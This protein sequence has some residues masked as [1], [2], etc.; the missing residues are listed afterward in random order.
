MEKHGAEKWSFI[1]SF[2]PERVGKQCRERWFNHLNP[3]VKKSTW[4]KEEEWILFLKHNEF[5]NK[6]SKLCQYLPGRTDNTIKN[7]W[8]S[9]MQKKILIFET[10]LSNMLQGKSPEEVESFKENFINQCKETIESD[11]LKFYDEKRKNYEKFKS[12]KYEN[13]ISMN[14]LK[15][16]L[17]FRTHSKKT[18]KKGRK[19]KIFIRTYIDD[20]KREIPQDQINNNITNINNTNIISTSPINCIIKADIN[21]INIPKDILKN[22]NN[23]IDVKMITPVKDNNKENKSDNINHPSLQEMNNSNSNSHSSNTNSFFNNNTKNNAFISL[24]QSGGSSNFK[25][26]RSAFNKQIFTNTSDFMNYSN[27]KAHLYFSSSIKKPV[28]IVSDDNYF[29]SSNKNCNNSFNGSNGGN[30][31]INNYVY[32]NNFDIFNNENITPNKPY[33]YNPNYETSFH[34]NFNIKILNTSNQKQ[35]DGNMIL[36]P[37][38][39]KTP[40]KLNSNANLDKIFFSNILQN[41]YEKTPYKNN[42]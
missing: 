21:S 27:V 32:N 3:D 35:F 34:K 23:N 14:K 20:P 28:K 6:W 2:F 29:S 26:E 42:I 1:S 15:K 8:N 36:H 13:K 24:N 19:K 9:T 39:D 25:L 11:N 12:L 37:L 30:V 7:H 4:L 22:N 40:L 18:K 16:I 33:L 31:Y 41:D 5:G 10:E 17:L 38:V